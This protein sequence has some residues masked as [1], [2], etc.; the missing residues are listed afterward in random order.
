MEEKN[1][2]IKNST[3]DK[4][5]ILTREEAEFLRSELLKLSTRHLLDITQ[6]IVAQTK[7]QDLEMA[8]SLGSVISD[9]RIEHDAIGKL[10]DILKEWN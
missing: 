8:M 4:E 6:L 1:I 2:Q 7:C 5:I 10:L 9:K 3:T